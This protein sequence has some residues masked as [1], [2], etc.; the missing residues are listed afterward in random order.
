M[1]PLGRRGAAVRVLDGQDTRR[2]ERLGLKSNPPS[3]YEQF[4]TQFFSVGD[5]L[6]VTETQRQDAV[7]LCLQA[8]MKAA[9]ACMQA[10]ATTDFRSD[11]PAVTVPT[12]VIHGAGDGTVPFEGSGRRTH[13]A[14]T[15]SELHVV[16]DAPQGFNVSRA[17][18]FNV[19]L[20]EF[21]AR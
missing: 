3:F 4:T 9:L 8:D 21:L 15:G 10:F 2:I 14:I 16:P 19:R 1:T 11:L 17:P 12:L 20:T 6:K 5:D 18:E 7:A 13:E